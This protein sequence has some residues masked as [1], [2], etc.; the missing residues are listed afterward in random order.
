[1]AIILIAI[2]KVVLVRV[3]KTWNPGTLLAG[4]EMVQSLQTQ[5]GDSSIRST[6]L[7]SDPLILL[8]AIHPKELK[9]GFQINTRT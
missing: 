5:F 4:R 2:K 9:A 8:L 7:P 6:E 3:C 1:V